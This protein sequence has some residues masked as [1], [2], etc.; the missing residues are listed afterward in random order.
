MVY[1]VRG[2]RCAALR[3]FV[4]HCRKLLCL[5]KPARWGGTGRLSIHM[6]PSINR[7]KWYQTTQNPN[8]DCLH[9][10]ALPK[11]AQRRGHLRW[12]AQVYPRSASKSPIYPVTH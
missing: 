2:A 11:Y 10:E 7:L 3:W 8:D 4:G 1:A 5:I 6:W 12:V 9:D